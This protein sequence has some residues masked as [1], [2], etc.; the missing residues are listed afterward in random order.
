MAY[1]NDRAAMPGLKMLLGTTTA[2]MNVA[3]TMSWEIKS[4][5]PDV[6][7]S[8]MSN[9]NRAALFL[10]CNFVNLKEFETFVIK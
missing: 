5:F 4:N 7:S 2:N 8:A 6:H 9:K 1:P 3:R 10:S